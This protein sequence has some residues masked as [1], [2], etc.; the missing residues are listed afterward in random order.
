MS[1]VPSLTSRPL[2]LALQNALRFTQGEG[3]VEISLAPHTEEGRSSLQLTVEDTGEGM[4]DEFVA[5]ALFKPFMKADKFK[6]GAGLGMALC[7]SLCKRMVSAA[8]GSLYPADSDKHCRAD[9]CK[10]P[11]MWGEARSSRS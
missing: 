10:S 1:A 5:E 6:S 4:T 7:A 8:Q 9:L 2:T 3:Y 11:A